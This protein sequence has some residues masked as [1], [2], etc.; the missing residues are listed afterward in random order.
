MKQYLLQ[1]IS[2]KKEIQYILSFAT[3][4]NLGLHCI[5]SVQSSLSFSFAEGI[6]LFMMI[7]AFAVLAAV[8]F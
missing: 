6:A 4:K 5:H 3:I 1:F 7:M 2:A 8:T